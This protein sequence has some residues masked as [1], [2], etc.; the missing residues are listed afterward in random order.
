VLE[1]DVTDHYPI[2]VKRLF[3][4]VYESIIKS[5]SDHSGGCVHGLLTEVGDILNKFTNYANRD[6]DFTNKFVHVTSILEL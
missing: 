6:I 4:K 2:Y 1:S 5:L 3:Q